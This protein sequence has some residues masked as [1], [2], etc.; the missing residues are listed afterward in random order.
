MSL[1]V[2]LGFEVRARAATRFW[3]PCAA[4]LK[5]G[6]SIHEVF[7]SIQGP[8]TLHFLAWCYRAWQSRSK[9]TNFQRVLG[10]LHEVRSRQVCLLL[11]HSCKGEARI[12]G[13]EFAEMFERI[14]VKG[15]RRARSLT[16]SLL[17]PSQP[18]LLPPLSPPPP[19]PLPS[20]RT[21]RP[22]ARSPACLPP[23]SP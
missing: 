3:R 10:D 6:P 5:H 11:S 12:R 2:V 18:L 8:D 23:S 7:F 22:L 4:S 17:S 21:N 9:L 16:R 15:P 14:S 20:N 13:A 1:H 19:P